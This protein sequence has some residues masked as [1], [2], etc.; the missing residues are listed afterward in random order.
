MLIGMVA[1]YEPYMGTPNPIGRW[2]CRKCNAFYTGS[3]R[4]ALA[5]KDSHLCQSENPDRD[6]PDGAAE[7]RQ[8][9]RDRREISLVN[10][11]LK[12]LWA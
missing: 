8:R 3:A 10:P 9:R 1:E 5:T 6:G 11:D 12:S 4:F 7:F 2:V